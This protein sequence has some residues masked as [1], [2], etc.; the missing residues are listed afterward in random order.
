MARD[1]EDTVKIFLLRSSQLTNAALAEGAAATVS[2]Q[3]DG[4]TIR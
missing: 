4:S 3:L 1:G 2:R